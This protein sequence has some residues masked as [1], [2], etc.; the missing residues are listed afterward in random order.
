MLQVKNHSYINSCIIGWY[1]KVGSWTRVENNSILGEGVATKDE[2]HL[3][4]AVILPHKEMKDSVPEP[5]II[6]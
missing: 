6:M 1:S 2:L 3:N 4:G 5:K